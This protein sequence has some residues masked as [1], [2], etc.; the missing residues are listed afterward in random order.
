MLRTR[1]WVLCKCLSLVLL[2]TLAT[3]RQVRADDCDP[4]TQCEYQNTCYGPN[5]CEIISQQIMGCGCYG[6][7]CGWIQGTW[8]G[9]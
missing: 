7:S 8:C 1:V 4:F 5:S 3:T 2:A 9:G 6:G